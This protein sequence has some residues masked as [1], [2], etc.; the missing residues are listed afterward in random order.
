MLSAGFAAVGE[1]MSNLAAKLLGD[2]LRKARE[3]RGLSVAEAAQILKVKRQTL[4]NYEKGRWLPKMRVL[5]A[6]SSAWNW[7]FELS[8]CN[9]VPQEPS[10]KPPAKRQEVQ[11][12]FRFGTARSYRAK[13]IRIRQRD[14]ELVITAVARISS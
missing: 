9:V 5:D 10:L 6:A 4:Y 11:T 1:E 2:Q 3:S 12:E 7:R 8:G 14:H 13:T